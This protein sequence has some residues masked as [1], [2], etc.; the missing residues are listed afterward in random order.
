MSQRCINQVQVMPNDFL[1]HQIEGMYAAM[2]DPSWKCGSWKAYPAWKSDTYPVASGLR[3]SGYYFTDPIGIAVHRGGP[4]AR[5]PELRH[6]QG[7][8]DPRLQ[9]RST[10]SRS[11]IGPIAKM[12][13]DANFVIY[14]SAINAGRAERPPPRSRRRR[15]RSVPYPGFDKPNT[16]A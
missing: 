1:E 9:R 13:P 5:R 3:R 8:P 11:D 15:P 14:H 7:P 10:T 12:Y 16:P 4:E 2:Q 6:P